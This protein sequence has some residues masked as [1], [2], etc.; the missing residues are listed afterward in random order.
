MHHLNK[1][2]F[3]DRIPQKKFAL[4]ATRYAMLVFRY[5]IL[6]MHYAI[7]ISCYVILVSRYKIFNER[8]AILVVS[9]LLETF[10][11]SPSCL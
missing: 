11:S 6:V 2:T 5:V 1:E 10:K 8:C 4:Q 7:L 3:N 9:E